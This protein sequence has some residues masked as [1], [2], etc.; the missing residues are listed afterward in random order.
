MTLPADALALNLF[1]H[2]SL[3]QPESQPREKKSSANRAR[4]LQQ[5]V[6]DFSD[7]FVMGTL[8]SQREGGTPQRSL[9]RSLSDEQISRINPR[10]L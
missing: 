5:E 9:R 4:R 2:R 6:M 3:L 10:P 8:A 1:P 7:R